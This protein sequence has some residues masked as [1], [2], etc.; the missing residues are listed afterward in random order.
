MGLL[1]PFLVAGITPASANSGFHGNGTCPHDNGTAD[2]SACYFGQIQYSV[3]S[4]VLPSG[5]FA[6]GQGRSSDQLR[7]RVGVYGGVNSQYFETGFDQWSSGQ[8]TY[9]TPYVSWENSNGSIAW[10]HTC[11]LGS[12]G[13]DGWTLASDYA[14]NGQWYGEAINQANHENCAFQYETP[15]NTGIYAAGVTEGGS[16]FCVC[17]GSGYF[18]D[19]S[20]MNTFNVLTTTICLTYDPPGFV[21][22]GP[23]T[24]WSTYA[25]DYAC[26]GTPCMNGNWFNGNWWSSNYQR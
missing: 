4:T 12:D 16:V 22:G 1:T 9:F 20:Y 23:T 26:P 7:Q 24:S 5:N 18:G 17:G 3:T 21:C 14:G 2:S 19:G 15:N 10:G 11:S 13:Y 6:G 25:I 8:F